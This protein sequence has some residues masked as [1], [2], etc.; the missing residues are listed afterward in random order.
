[1]QH[2]SCVTSLRRVA[3]QRD[4]QKLT[5][6]LAIQK[7]ERERERVIA[8]TEIL[9]NYKWS[10]LCFQTLKTYNER[11][12]PWNAQL[13]SVQRNGEWPRTQ[14]ST[15]AKRQTR[16]RLEFTK[17]KLKS[18]RTSRKVNNRKLNILI[19]PIKLQYLMYLE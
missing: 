3:L 16:V 2:C 12:A 19:V 8:L 15:E 4:K 7:R 17:W 6:L 1:M 9:S 18:G 14:T 5:E 10:H 13:F 11:D